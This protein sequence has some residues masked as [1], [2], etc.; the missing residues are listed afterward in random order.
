MAGKCGSVLLGCSLESGYI[1][2]RFVVLFTDR[3]LTFY[4]VNICSTY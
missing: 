2:L 4:V 1:Q 3:C